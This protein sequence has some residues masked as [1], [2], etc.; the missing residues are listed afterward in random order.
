MTGTAA[1]C[2]IRRYQGTTDRFIRNLPFQRFVREVAQDF[3]S[4]SAVSLLQ[5]VYFKKRLPP[6]LYLPLK[7]R[8]SAP[9][10]RGV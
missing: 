10:V 5:F 1:L 7:A 6:M 9:F 4:I 3:K 2:E 8:T